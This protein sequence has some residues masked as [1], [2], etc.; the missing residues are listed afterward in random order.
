MDLWGPTAQSP[1]GQSY[2]HKGHFYLPFFPCVNTDADEAK[3]IIGKIAGALA[4]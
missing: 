2:F 3:A 1:E 4:N